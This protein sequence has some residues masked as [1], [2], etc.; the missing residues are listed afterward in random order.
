MRTWKVLSQVRVLEKVL[1][2]QPWELV[3]GPL[4]SGPGREQQVLPS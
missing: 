1:A 3:L 4:A 2:R